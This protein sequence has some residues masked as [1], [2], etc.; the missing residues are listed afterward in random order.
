M[1]GATNV[2]SCAHTAV[3]AR[4]VKT[5]RSRRIGRVRRAILSPASCHARGG[6]GLRRATRHRASSTAAM[7][8]GPRFDRFGVSWTSSY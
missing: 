4:T 1:V 8:S 3:A 6:S 2:S 7:G 5:P